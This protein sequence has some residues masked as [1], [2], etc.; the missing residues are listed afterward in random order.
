MFSQQFIRSFSN[1]H[2]CKRAKTKAES[3]FGLARLILW[4]TNWQISFRFMSGSCLTRPVYP[5]QTARARHR[6]TDQ[7][8]LVACSRNRILKL[9]SSYQNLHAHAARRGARHGLPLL[10]QPVRGK[11]IGRLVSD[12]KCRCCLHRWCEWLVLFREHTS[13]QNWHE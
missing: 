1:H 10:L 5:R 8:H 3:T 11:K 4:V 12:H 6:P 7:P 9:H 2:R 13:W